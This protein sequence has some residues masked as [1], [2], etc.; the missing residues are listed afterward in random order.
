MN[1]EDGDR[2]IWNDA[3]ATEE[4]REKIA[5]ILDRDSIRGATIA[6]VAD[7]HA[8]SFAIGSRDDDPNNTTPL[9]PGALSPIYSITKMFIASA[10]LRLVES[11]VMS[12]VESVHSILPWIPLDPA[13]TLRQVLNHTSG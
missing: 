9:D 3:E 11:G 4:I 10:I 6:I 1:A 12:L 8:C 7:G 2:S 13:I 5:D